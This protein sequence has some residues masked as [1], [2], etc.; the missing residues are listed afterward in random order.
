MTQKI[1]IFN[2]F[3]TSTK[4]DDWFS[5]ISVTQKSIFKDLILINKILKVKF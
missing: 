2:P 1:Y 5:F 4:I 3:F